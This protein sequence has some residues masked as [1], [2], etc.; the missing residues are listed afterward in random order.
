MRNVRDELDGFALQCLISIEKRL[1]LPQGYFLQAFGQGDTSLMKYSQWHIK[2]YSNITTEAH[3]THSE[4]LIAEEENSMLLLPVHT[5]PS[6]LSIIVHDAPG[7][8]NG[9]WGLEYAT[10]PRQQ[11]EQAS[12]STLPIWKEIPSHGHGIATVMIGSAFGRIMQAGA[13]QTSSTNML[14]EAIRKLYPPVRHRVKKS[15]ATASKGI[16]R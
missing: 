1:E 8:C 14:N 3:V 12:S 11:D 5:D 15:F 16:I 9:G 7:I 4:T 13:P 10:K 2:R 6:L